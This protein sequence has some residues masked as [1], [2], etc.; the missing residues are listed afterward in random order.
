MVYPIAPI[1]ERLKKGPTLWGQWGL[2]E[3]EKIRGVLVQ[4]RDDVD[5][6]GAIGPRFLSVYGEEFEIYGRRG[7]S[8]R[9]AMSSGPVSS[10]R[11]WE[12]SKVKG[13]NDPIRAYLG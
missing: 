9:M 10:G 1:T 11:C 6:R 7:G 13:R 4:H 2:C 5:Q 12:I 3:E 8:R